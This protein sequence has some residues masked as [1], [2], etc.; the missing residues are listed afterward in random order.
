MLNLVAGTKITHVPFKGSGPAL[1]ALLGGHVSMQFGGISSAA[2]Y[3][4]DGKKVPT[5]RVCGACMHRQVRRSRS[6]ALCAMP[7][8]R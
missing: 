3:I 5:S 7:W 4:K 1:I 2:P 8:P 6:D